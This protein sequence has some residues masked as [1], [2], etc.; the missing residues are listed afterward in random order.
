MPTIQPLKKVTLAVQAGGAR[1]S[2]SL[3][4]APVTL[5]FIYGVGSDGLSSFE[6]ALGERSP[7]EVVSFSVLNTDAADF[8]GNLYLPLR[9][10]IGL[11]LPPTTLFLQLEIK[12]VE[13]AD[14]REVVKALAGSL[15]HSCG[16][17]S[18]D[19]GCS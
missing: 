2:F 12:A 8:F 14:N 15:S 6:V 5:D 17:G 11:H 4:P 18:C 19:C 16:G 7:G 3:T 13:D 10:T 9:Q 1:G